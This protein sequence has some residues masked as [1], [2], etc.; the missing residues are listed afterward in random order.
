[1]RLCAAPHRPHASGC[2]DASCPSA[3]CAGAPSTECG[4]HCPR[5]ASGWSRGRMLLLGSPWMRVPSAGGFGAHSLR[6][7]RRADAWSE[8]PAAELGGCACAER[9]IAGLGPARGRERQRSITMEGSG[10]HL[11]KFATLGALS[12]PRHHCEANQPAPRLGRGPGTRVRR[13]T[14][15][16]GA[17]LPGSPGSRLHVCDQREGRR[18]QREP[19]VPQAAHLHRQR[20]PHARAASARPATRRAMGGGCAVAPA[21]RRR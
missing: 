3:A 20:C 4:P 5:G 16:P 7:P 21:A 19:P 1:M 10:G 2:P 17:A 12:R 9:K 15:R 8:S 6:A 14:R 18:G 11:M 13:R